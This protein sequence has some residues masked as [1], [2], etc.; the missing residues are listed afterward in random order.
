MTK[1]SVGHKIESK[2]FMQKNLATNAYDK[3]PPNTGIGVKNL[4]F[5]YETTRRE[6]QNYLLNDILIEWQAIIEDSMVLSLP[7][8][9]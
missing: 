2:G 4:V 8:L 7:L 1:K 3:M 5:K 9:I 6:L